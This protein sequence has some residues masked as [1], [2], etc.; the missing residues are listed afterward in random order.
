MEFLLSNTD[1]DTDSQI[2]AGYW[3]KN[4]KK[5]PRRSIIGNNM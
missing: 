3:R 4:Y 1:T 5:W 2:V